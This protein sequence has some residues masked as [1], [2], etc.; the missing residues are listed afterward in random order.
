MFVRHRSGIVTASLLSAIVVGCDSQ[1]GSQMLTADGP[2]HLEDHLGA[3]TLTGSD[4]SAGVTEPV[5]WAAEG[6]QSDWRLVS[7]SGSPSVSATEEGL[8]VTF[9]RE[10]R[11]EEFGSVDLNVRLPEWNRADWGTIALRLRATGRRM[12]VTLGMNLTTTDE[13]PLQG[14]S[15]PVPLQADGDTHTYLLR[16]AQI[17]GVPSSP[18]TELGVHLRA[19]ST[20]TVDVLSVR[21]IPIDAEFATEP[22]GVRS[23]ARGIEHRR[24]IFVHAP[25]SLEYRVKV[26]D[27]GRLDVGLGV[28][29]EDTPVT[30]EVTAT[31]EAGGVQ[32]LATETHDA[33]T[34]WA[35]L[36]VDLS[37]M[38]GQTVAL[39][40]AVDAAPGTVGLWAAPT[41]SGRVDS[42]R[43]NVVFYVIDGAS[44]EHMSLY[45]YNRRTTPNLERLAEEGA[46]F[47]YAY[48]NSSWTGSSTPSFLTSL[49][50]SAIG[51][52]RRP[53]ILPDEALTA[54][55]HLHAVGYQ[56]GLFT[57]NANAGTALGLG[58][59]SDVLREAYDP[60]SSAELQA[61]F[62]RWREAY[63][64]EPYWVHFQTTDVHGPDY[65]G[66]SFEGL[67]VSP[68][69]LER[70]E[71]WDAALDR[72][73]W[74]GTPYSDAFEAAGVDRYAYFDLARA[75]YD[76]TM[77]QQDARIG[78]FVGRLKAE[79]E[80]ENTLLII[81]SDHGHQAGTTHF[82][83]GLTDPLPD[84]WEGA[85]LSSFQSR[86]PLMFVWPG[87]IAGGLRFMDPVSMIDVLPTVL[88]LLGLPVPEYA[89]G[90]SL[91]PLLLGR[92]GWEPSPVV[93]D[94][95]RFEDDELLGQIEVIDGRWGAS[96]YV[97][98]PRPD[99]WIHLR[100]HRNYPPEGSRFRD[101]VPDVT[102]PLLLYDV[103]SDPHALR[104]L[105]EE[106][107]ALV[108]EYT[109]FLEAR[110]AQ[111][112]R[113]A[114]RFTQTG[115]NPALTEE[116][117][118]TLRS[119][120]YIR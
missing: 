34:E 37:H 44:P 33:T 52:V 73:G 10:A 87:R 70:L 108:K 62:W 80:W 5:E 59:G 74:V 61:Q 115:D 19:D 39:T 64:G 85:M 24:S 58:R 88:D 113:L 22:A 78:Q 56:T 46:V 20:A 6:L 106:R 112:L 67:Y 98:P 2:L 91:A 45:R 63:P 41:V 49:H 76:Q 107:P 109:A 30:F 8:R 82:G 75:A 104:S 96:L 118:R 16:V 11:E 84:I 101:G 105:H 116:Q 36:G 114:E 28:L 120:G 97:G 119:L 32:R 72:Q 117:L 14:W 18:W 51:G 3:A 25:A 94:E 47:E 35:Q 55:E 26:P 17:R 53:R 92:D 4:L 95:F 60:N 31:D 86:V 65:M 69:Y 12:R 103:W 48:S 93:F 66:P 42:G 90:R 111:H 40:L 99:G 83:L 68:E 38:A 81:A 15:V 77:A 21:A 23:V 102:P 79:G 71:T 7:S 57:T 50:T 27:G 43:P 54:A 29:R 110:L 89:Q 1:S 13:R 9:D 100:G